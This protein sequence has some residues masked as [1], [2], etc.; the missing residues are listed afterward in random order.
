M[1]GSF[2][3]KVRKG[4]A[5]FIGLSL[6]CGVWVLWNTIPGLPHFD[7]GFG[8]LNL[9]LSIEASIASSVLL[10]ANE[11]QDE[12]QRR[13]LVLLLH[14]MEAVHAQLSKADP[15]QL[16]GQGPETKAPGGVETEPKGSAGPSPGDDQPS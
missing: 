12:L 13:Q 4:R 6:F 10:A 3:A 7:Q 2:Y 1:S 9:V 15:S 5:F 8:E 14:L 11:K 16:R